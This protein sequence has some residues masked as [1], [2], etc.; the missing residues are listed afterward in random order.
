MRRITRRDFLKQTGK[1]ALAASVGF[2]SGVAC[3]PTLKETKQ[4]VAQIK[5]DCNP[6][7]PI[8]K[9]GCY[10][11]TNMQSV[12]GGTTNFQEEYG[13]TPT[14]NAW[15][16][17]TWATFNEY[18]VKDRHQELIDRGTIPVT[19]YITS[20]HTGYKPIIEGK[21]DDKFKSFANQAAEFGHPII[22]LPWQGANEP[23]GRIWHWSGA[24]PGQYIEAWIRMHNIFQSEGANKNVVWSTKLLNGGW[25]GWEHFDPLTYIPPKD[26]VDIVGWLCTVKLESARRSNVQAERTFDAQFQSDYN[27][28]ASRYPTKPQMF[29][30]LGASTGPE[31]APWMDNALE[32]IR[33]H[34]PR[35]KGVMLDVM[36]TAG[37]NP[38]HTSET[39]KVIRRHFASGYFKG[40]L[41]NK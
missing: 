14:F 11:G 26:Y 30:E 4:D 16:Q 32:R 24:P 8:P 3:A 41:I 6:I 18:F 17:G 29:W 23:S 13:I 10:A 27:R 12:Q 36:A 2:E 39:I 15:G 33:T 5:W 37:Y 20:P 35:V 7:L 31:Q 1:A 25:P 22:L 28:A 34:Y 40:S 19:R 38:K 9:E 21:F